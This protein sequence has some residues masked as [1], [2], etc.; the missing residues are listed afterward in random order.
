MIDKGSLN[1]NFSMIKNILSP[2]FSC[3][4][5]RLFLLDCLTYSIQIMHLIDYNKETCCICHTLNLTEIKW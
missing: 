4:N 2:Q 1:K 5:F 3:S